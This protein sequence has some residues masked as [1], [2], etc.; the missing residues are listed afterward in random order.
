MAPQINNKFLESYF[1]KV[2]S[3]MKG[4]AIFMLNKEGVIAT[5]NGGCELMKEYNSDEAIGQHYRLLFPDFLIEKNYPEAELREAEVKG[6]FESENWRR[7]K[8]GELF[9]AFVVLT[10]LTD[11]RGN[12]IG[13][14]KITQDLSEKKKFQDELELKN[15]K[16]ARINQDLD[17]FV[18]TASHD[19]KIPINKISGQVIKLEEQLKNK[20]KEEEETFTITNQIKQ[21]ILEFEDIISEMAS[22]TKEE[23]ENE[24]IY[25]SFQEIANEV[26]NNLSQEIKNSKAVIVENYSNAPAVRFSRKDIRIILHH[27]LLNSIKYRSSE[28]SPKILIQT[29]YQNGFTILE[30]SDNG[31]GIKDEDKRRIFSMFNSSGGEDQNLDPSAV[32][33]AIIARIV[34]DNGGK[35]DINSKP[36]EGTLFRIYIQ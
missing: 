8:S 18:Y 26:K 21:S 16:L 27:L 34:N 31:S 12:F 36:D 13:F 32:S 33:L 6:R 24:K 11:E 15:Q 29:N 20:V 30:V 2:I 7:R 1:P 23:P 22:K 28:K 14:T 9:W 19:L 10:K 3:E 35:I 5:W 25:L 17:H 4:F